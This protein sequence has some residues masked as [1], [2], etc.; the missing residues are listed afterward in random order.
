MLKSRQFLE[1]VAETAISAFGD[2]KPQ[3]RSRSTLVQ[4]YFESPAQH[5]EVWLRQRSSLLELG[6]HFEGPR[7][8]NLKRLA[9]LAEVMPDVIARLG[10]EVE[11]EEWTENWTR[12]HEARPLPALDE[13]TA[14]D[15]GIRLAHYM[16]VLQP[17]V[18]ALGPMPEPLRKAGWNRRRRRTGSAAT[19]RVG[20]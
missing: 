16:T 1:L 7:E 4:L 6:L 20:P 13:S 11:I 10:P 15:T 3:V 9:V 14:L 2:D 19:P 17:L 18:S 8:E 12:L 5:Y